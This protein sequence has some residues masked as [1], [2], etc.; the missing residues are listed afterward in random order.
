MIVFN[1]QPKTKRVMKLIE[2]LYILSSTI[3]ILS[4]M[5]QVMQLLRTKASEELSVPTWSMWLATQFVS[6]AY[7]ANLGN[8]L[9]MCFSIAW[10]S[11]YTVMMVL[12]IRYRRRPA[13][14]M[15]EAVNEA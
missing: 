9:L 7:M 8:L 12:I 3:A 5:P 14:E 13:P 15:V 11:F 6:V 4:S 10:L 2:I 1:N